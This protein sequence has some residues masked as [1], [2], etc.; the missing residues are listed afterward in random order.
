[1][2]VAELRAS[3]ETSTWDFYCWSIKIGIIDRVEKNFTNWKHKFIS[4]I[5]KEI[6]IKF[7]LQVIATY[8]MS[9]CFMPKTLSH[10][11]SLQN[12]GEVHKITFK[13]FIRRAGIF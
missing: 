10:I 3:L 2:E 5:R 12:F 13:K 6:L 1:M 9:V 8:S 11:H 4:T 7:V